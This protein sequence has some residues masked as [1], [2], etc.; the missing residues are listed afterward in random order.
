MG[1]TLSII[2][3]WCAIAFMCAMI[4]GF[5]A[6]S[7]GRSGLGFALLGLFFGP[8]GFLLVG[9]AQPASAYANL[10]PGSSGRF[11]EGTENDP[12]S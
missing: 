4:S 2:V 6:I 7:K 3:T 10:P 12:A 8:L 11:G 5:V 9:F 1:I